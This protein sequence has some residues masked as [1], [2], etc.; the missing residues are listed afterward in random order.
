MTGG[1]ENK[2]RAQQQENGGLIIG[3]G[4]SYQSL[5]GSMLIELLLSLR[6]CKSSTNAS[7]NASPQTRNPFKSSAPKVL[8]RKRR[9]L[10]ASRQTRNPFKS[11]AR[12]VPNKVKRRRRW[13]EGSLLSPPK[14]IFV[15]MCSSRLYISHIHRDI[16][17][18]VG[19]FRFVVCL[20]VNFIYFGEFVL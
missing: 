10:N 20:F 3:K 6:I 15:Y 19:V 14:Q 12:K 13:H 2:K 16:N 8:I 5:G 7:W 18:W 1:G 11:N 9:G 4:I 17:V